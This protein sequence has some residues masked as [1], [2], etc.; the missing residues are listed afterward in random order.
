M[1]LLI[2]NKSINQ[3]QLITNYSEPV[4]T[5]PVQIS[6]HV[7]YAPH[8]RALQK[9]VEGGAGQRAVLSCVV[10][11]QPSPDTTWYKNNMALDSR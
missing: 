10:H 8:V 1:T 6:L 4:S 5:S 7:L 11:A 9:V 3:K 2:I